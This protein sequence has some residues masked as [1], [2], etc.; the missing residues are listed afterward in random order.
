[1]KH[2]IFQ[3][4]ESLIKLFEI[5]ATI[6]EFNIFENSVDANTEEVIKMNEF[7]DIFEK[8]M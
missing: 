4:E 1:M 2:L 5:Y 6:R 8:V 7:K 3:N